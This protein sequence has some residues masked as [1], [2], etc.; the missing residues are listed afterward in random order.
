MVFQILLKH[1]IF[2]R[3][4]LKISACPTGSWNGASIINLF[5]SKI[6]S[7]IILCLTSLSF[8][9]HS[10]SHFSSLIPR[11]ATWPGNVLCFPVFINLHASVLTLVI[12]SFLLQCVS[13]WTKRPNNY[14]VSC[15]FFAV[16]HVLLLFCLLTSKN[17]WK[18]IL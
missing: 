15:L 9:S 18:S 17:D 2:K 14:L 1:F 12:S 10:T 7:L 6:A 11:S 5:H 8:L 4:T 13:I 16:G 3:N